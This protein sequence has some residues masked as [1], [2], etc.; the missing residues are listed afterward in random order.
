MSSGTTKPD[1]TRLARLVTAHVRKAGLVDLDRARTDA[2][3]AV[4]ADPAI[5]V[6]W[7]DTTSMPP[8]CSVAASYDQATGVISVSADAS[9]G[10]RSFSVLHEYAHHVAPDV[11][12]VFDT[13]CTA[14]DAQDLE[15][16][17]CDAFAAEVLLPDA[18]VDPS[19]AQGITAAAVLSLMRRST[20]SREACCVAAARRLPAPGY[21]MVLDTTGDA[22]FTARKGDVY[23]VPRGTR[24]D[25]HTC[26][27]ALQT[28]RGRG[29]A[30]PRTGHGITSAEMYSDIAADGDNI[31]AVWV[32]D[33]P[34]WPSGLTVGPRER[35]AGIAGYCESCTREFEVFTS[36]CTGCGEPCCPD[37]GNCGCLGSRPV[38]GERTCTR[39]FLPRPAMAFPGVGDVCEDH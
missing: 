22:R 29:R 2:P 23:P 5:T 39:C 14:K 8:A 37:C 26:N 21:V 3:G 31:V 28:G 33:S 10:R 35:V 27:R 24:Q 25:A 32:T 9:P 12:E 11:D 30:Q 6:R 20:A 16:R 13:L 34:D 4:V 1:P 36:P 15:E 19:L 17:I 7:T 38:R 18:H